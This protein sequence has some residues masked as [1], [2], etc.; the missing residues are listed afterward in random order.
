MKSISV[1]FLLALLLVVF[2]ATVAGKDINPHPRPFKGNMGGE[3]TFDFDFTAS[4]CL[5][6]TGAPWQTFST[7]SGNLT[8]LG[9][10]EYYSVHC[11]TLDGLQ[12]LNGEATLVAANGD[13]IWLN[14]TAELISHTELPPPPVDLVYLAR[15]VVVGGTGRFD[16]ASGEIV[17]FMHVEIESL[18]ILITTINGEFVGSITY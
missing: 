7:M 16:G 4:P 2:S 3:A 13:E 6:V 18:M 10:A 9:L 5:Q 1:R 12:L 8:H 17:S 14:Y 11:S 15:N